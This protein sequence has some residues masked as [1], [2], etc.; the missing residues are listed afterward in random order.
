MLLEIDAAAPESILKE[1]K[2]IINGTSL[3]PK[4]LKEKMTKEWRY[5]A[6]LSCMSHDSDRRR[7]SYVTTFIT[8][9]SGH[10][11]TRHT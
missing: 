7:S 9:G 2:E 1:I 3:V 8:N 5:P 6:R 11:L 4:N 10:S